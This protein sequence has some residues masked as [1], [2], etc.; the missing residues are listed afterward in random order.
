MKSKKAQTIVSIYD[1]SGN[2]CESEPVEQHVRLIF[3]HI[4]MLCENLESNGLNN[5]QAANIDYELTRLYNALSYSLH[6]I[7]YLVAEHNFPY[8]EHDDSRYPVWILYERSTDK[9]LLFDESIYDN[10]NQN[11]ADCLSEF[12]SYTNVN[13]PFFKHVYVNC[14]GVASTMKDNILLCYSRH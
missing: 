12:Q 13:S 14:N 10:Y 9:I 7:E 4:A 5:E 3:K 1:K 11:P 2:L 6:H 8:K